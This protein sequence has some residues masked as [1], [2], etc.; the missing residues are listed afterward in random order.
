MPTPLMDKSYHL[1]HPRP[2]KRKFDSGGTYSVYQPIVEIGSGKIFGYEALT[3]GI[4]R[5]RQPQ[6]LFRKAYEAGD[7]IEFDLKCL[8]TTLR[9]FPKISKDQLLFV[10][11]EPVTLGYAFRRGREVQKILDRMKSYA[12]QIVFEMTEGMKLRDFDLV[13][14]GFHF[15]KKYQCRFALDDIDGVDSKLLKLLTLKPDYIKIDMSLIQHIT[16]HPIHQKLV[17]QLIELGKKKNFRIIAEGIE[18]EKDFKIVQSLGIQY[19]QGFLFARPQRKLR[20]TISWP[21]V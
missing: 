21:T 13:K 3:R 15:L 4:A 8:R 16:D 11:I 9:S 1:S 12:N 2:K 10:N 18:N 14:Q 5:I 19:V 20:K 6:E 7:A 17:A